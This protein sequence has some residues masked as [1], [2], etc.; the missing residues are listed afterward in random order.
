[1]EV[2]GGLFQARYPIKPYKGFL[3]RPIECLGIE[4]DASIKQTAVYLANGTDT[5]LEAAR[6]YLIEQTF[7]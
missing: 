4:P 7:R 3:D 6:K 1:M 5:V 2:C